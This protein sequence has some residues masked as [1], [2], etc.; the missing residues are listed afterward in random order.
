M[1]DEVNKAVALPI[2]SMPLEELSRHGRRTLQPLLER[3][4]AE[5][6]VAAGYHLGRLLIERAA[7]C[8]YPPPQSRP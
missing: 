4:L 1:V 5:G 8:I 6:E 2:E 3:A 7:S